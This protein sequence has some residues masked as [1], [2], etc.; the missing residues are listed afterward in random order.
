MKMTNKEY[1]ERN[2]KGF[3]GDTIM[4][5]RVAEIIKENKIH[6][7][8]ETGTYLGGTTKLFS[9]MVDKVHT[10]ELMD[11]NFN[12]SKEYLK[13]NP[14]VTIHKGSS[15]TVL[16]EL[17][18]KVDKKST[19]K[20]KIFMF[21][22]AHFY[23]YNP[24]LDELAVIAKNKL[25]PIIAIHDFKVP[26]HPELGFDTYGKIVYEWDW[27]KSSIEKIYGVDG[28]ITEYNSEATGAKR[29]I[30]YIYPNK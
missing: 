15:E 22:D 29:G 8:Y 20:N 24:L 26:G 13:D 27:I 30:I 21:L 16:G 28:Y 18:S 23:D 5:N 25:K 11:E 14:N 6:T 7:V 3:E 1:I 10:I 9:E 19:L 12:K 4:K 2:L 17:L